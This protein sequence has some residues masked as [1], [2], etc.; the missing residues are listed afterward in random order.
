MADKFAFVD[1]KNHEVV[2]KTREGAVIS[3]H[4]YKGGRRQGR[5]KLHAVCFEEGA[6]CS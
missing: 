2:V 1:H 6:K 5:K 4:S 3:K